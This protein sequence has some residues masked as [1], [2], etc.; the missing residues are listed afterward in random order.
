MGLLYNEFFRNSEGY[1]DPT[2]FEAIK[3]ISEEDAAINQDL[4]NLVKVLK[5][6]IG[7]SDFE[8]IARIELKHTKTG[9]VF[10]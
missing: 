3:A 8:L 7:K 1:A 10:R 4:Y 9:R 2:A 5:Y 6:I